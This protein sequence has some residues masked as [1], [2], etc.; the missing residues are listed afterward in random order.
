M[1][2]EKPLQDHV[3]TLEQG[4]HD[5]HVPH[6][7]QQWVDD[8]RVPAIKRRVDIRICLVLGALY[9][10]NQIDRINLGA[11]QVAGMGKNLGYVGNQ[12][13][14]VVVVLFPTYIIVQP[15]ATV[16]CRK[17]GPR[18]FITGIV[19]GWGAATIGIGFAKNFNTVVA[20]RVLLGLFEG[21]FFPSALFLLS[22]WYIRAEVAKRNAVLYLCGTIASGFGGILA[23]GVRM[24]SRCS[25]AGL[26]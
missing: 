6:T 17:I 11:A 3:E 19:I 15:V 25:F 16:A 2:A 21:G 4:K 8:P 10:I 24:N 14:T 5:T 26:S 18:N 9:V 12:Y 22:M 7:V 1:S 23:Y 13:T 20:M